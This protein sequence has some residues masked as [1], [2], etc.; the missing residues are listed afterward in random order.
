MATIGRKKALE[1]MRNS[2]GRF[3]SAT[4]VDKKGNTKTLVCRY[5]KDQTESLLGYVRVQDASNFYKKPGIKTVNLQT[6]I[7][8]KESGT[9]YKIR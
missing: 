9:V 5:L 7:S 1:I 6:L 4:F 2:G 3:I 8:L